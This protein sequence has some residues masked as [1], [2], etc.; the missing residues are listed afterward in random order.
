MVDPI[1]EV[2]VLGDGRDVLVAR[3]RDSEA[4]LDEDARVTLTGWAPDAV[5]AARDNAARNGVML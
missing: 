2:V 5:M 1:V 4:L 3:P